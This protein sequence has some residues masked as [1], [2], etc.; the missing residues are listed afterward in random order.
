MTVRYMFCTKIVKSQRQDFWRKKIINIGGGGN[1]KWDGGSCDFFLRVGPG[2]WG[3]GK[4]ELGWGG[5][6]SVFR[7]EGDGG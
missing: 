2:G 5:V 6:C 1:Y 3:E 4:F 7:G